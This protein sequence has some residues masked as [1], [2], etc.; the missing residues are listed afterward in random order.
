MNVVGEPSSLQ[1]TQRPTGSRQTQVTQKDEGNV[2]LR[3]CKG[4]GQAKNEMTYWYPAKLNER[5][6]MIS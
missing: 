4:S 3:A 5:G 2:Y 6:R 1:K